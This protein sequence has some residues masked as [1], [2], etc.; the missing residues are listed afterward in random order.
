MAIIDST[1]Y[2]N[3]AYPSYVYAQTHP[4]R[5]ATIATIFGMSPAPI[6]ACR[7][8]ELGCGAGGNLI[9]MAF[10]LSGSEFVGIDLAGSAIAQGQRTIDAL[11]LRNIS[12]Q[13]IDL[14]D[15]SS[16]VGKFDY[17]IAHGLF[18]W[19]PEVVRDRILALC[20]KH[21]AP[22]GVAYISYNAYPGCHLREIARD[23]MRF[24]SKD[25]KAAAEKVGQSRAVIKWVV[26]AQQQTNSY[27]TF[28]KEMNAR[29][30]KRDDGSIFHDELAEVNEPLYFYQFAEAA[31]EHGLQFLS[32]ADYFEESTNT[33]LSPEAAGQLDH[34]GQEDILAREQYLDFLKGRSF[35]Q[36]LLC[37]SEVGVTRPI[38]S[39][40]LKGLL[41]KANV[42][43]LSPAPDINS[44]SVEQFRTKNGAAAATDQP[45]SKAAFVHL[46]RIYPLAISI[47]EL[48]DQA[49]MLMAASAT[50]IAEDI[51]VLAE[52][53]LKTYEVGVIELHVQ[54]PAYTLEP[55]AFPIASPL[56]RLQLREGPIV[57]TLLHGSL[58]LE[59]ELAR[60]LLLLLDGSRDRLA[61]VEEIT[62]I[63]NCSP[64]ETLPGKGGE[65]E[66]IAT[67]LEN[68][69]I[70]LGKLGLLLA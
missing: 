32:E 63:M 44:R 49:R 15:V 66:S 12:L 25:R 61:L 35:R 5:L 16:E 59:D 2:D 51:S 70:E 11:G 43:S 23:I 39:E 48:V 53:L 20:R 18:S 29:L 34:L 68:K 13:K 42:Q 33:I 54:E 47:E 52:V 40:K 24:H 46:G 10:A 55:T 9:P 69:L 41:I 37:H 65:P 8:L 31:N 27:A 58:R 50:T 14:M 6:A 21:L 64:G 3:V 1:A 38:S 62:R 17:I 60:R 19:V 56:A 30:E 36:S 22:E 45:L 67:H 7:V 4:D 28:L 26:E 57:S